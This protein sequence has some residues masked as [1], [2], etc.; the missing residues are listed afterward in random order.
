MR[1]PE[2][3]ARGSN[4]RP[5][6]GLSCRAR[7]WRHQRD[8]HGVDGEDPQCLRRNSED[9]AAS[10]SVDIA[11]NARLAAGI[12]AEGRLPVRCPAMSAS[13]QDRPGSAP[14]SSRQA[15]DVCVLFSPPPKLHPQSVSFGSWLR[16]TAAAR[17][18]VIVVV[19]MGAAPRDAIGI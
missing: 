10:G 2:T 18:Q 8:E 1:S 9:E 17:H 13:S 14:L 3:I 6:Q 19:G 16:E 15:L 11:G 12:G 7:D 5:T 4:R